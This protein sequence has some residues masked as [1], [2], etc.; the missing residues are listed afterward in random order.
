M[1][2]EEQDISD[3]TGCQAVSSVRLIVDGFIS[4]LVCRHSNTAIACPVSPSINFQ[5]LQ[6]TGMA[7]AMVGLLQLSRDDTA[8]P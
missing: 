3:G 8:G 2:Q 4:L 5:G 1:V 6:A 7:R